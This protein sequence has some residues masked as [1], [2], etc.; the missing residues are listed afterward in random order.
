MKSKIQQKQ[1][2]NASTAALNI[3]NY[4]KIRWCTDASLIFFTFILEI[5]WCWLLKEDFELSKHWYTL[6]P[7]LVFIVLWILNYS[8][9]HNFIVKHRDNNVFWKIV[10]Y[11]VYCAPLIISFATLIMYMFLHDYR[12]FTWVTLMFGLVFAVDLG[13]MLYRWTY[14]VLPN[15]FLSA[16]VFAFYLVLMTLPQEKTVLLH[17]GV[18]DDEMMALFLTDKFTTLLGWGILSTVLTTLISKASEDIWHGFSRSGTG[19]YA[20]I[21]YRF[22][23]QRRKLLSYLGGSGNTI[24]SMS[25]MSWV[26]IGYL[27]IFLVEAVALLLRKSGNVLLFF[28]VI[29]L[30][31]A[32][33]AVMGRILHLFITDEAL[34]RAEKSYLIDRKIEAIEC[35][36]QDPP[37]EK[38]GWRWSCF[39]Q[40]FVN[41]YCS[42]NP[43]FYE[44]NLLHE[45]GPVISY[46]LELDLQSSPICHGRVLADFVNYHKEQFSLYCGTEASPERDFMEAQFANVI[47]FYL[48]FFGDS[49]PGEAIDFTEDTMAL[50]VLSKMFDFYFD[51]AESDTLS[52]RTLVTIRNV[53]VSDEINLIL[54]DYIRLLTSDRAESSCKMCEW[55][56]KSNDALET[57]LRPAVAEKWRVSFPSLVEQLMIERWGEENLTTNI[58]HGKKLEPADAFR[59]M[60][61]NYQKK[62]IKEARKYGVGDE[63]Y[64]K[65]GIF[66]CLC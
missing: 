54:L 40:V 32:A 50:R 49:E 20:K 19:D 34:M 9:D 57:Y 39:C 24:A 1:H 46:F 55:C 31:G 60:E 38:L 56:K 18:M 27:A 64:W 35:L 16:S 65:N 61:E 58:W 25:K 48:R 43:I 4:W 12:L 51:I 63:K 7:L 6:I 26:T 41:M 23:R 29:F 3:S 42:R 33:C 30:V 13:F 11:I 14:R 10:Y 28:S 52:V 53:S 8:L 5:V 21:D 45:V 66:F 17:L 59:I 15:L 47:A 2:K 37:C 62:W 36:K 22:K 44:N